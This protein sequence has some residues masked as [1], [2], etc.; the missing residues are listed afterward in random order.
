M[1]VRGNPA[2]GEFVAV[3]PP[4][5][6]VFTWGIEGRSDLPAGQQHRRGGVAVRAATRPSSPSPTGTS[7]TEDYRRSHDEGWSEFLAVL[8]QVAVAAAP[9]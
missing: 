9:G 5:R 1:D 3:E 7:P 4:H 6:V 8:A 2:L